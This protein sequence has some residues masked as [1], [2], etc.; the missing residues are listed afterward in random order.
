[1]TPSSNKSFNSGWNGIW[2]ERTRPWISCHGGQDAK[3]PCQT[4]SWALVL[5]ISAGPTIPLPPRASLIRWF[6]LAKLLPPVPAFG[7]RLQP[8]QQSLPWPSLGWQRPAIRLPPPASTGRLRTIPAAQGWLVSRYQ[9]PHEL[10]RYRG[11]QPPVSAIGCRC[12]FFMKHELI[13]IPLLGL[14]CWGWM[15][16]CAAIRE[17]FC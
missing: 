14:A 3:T 1:M 12:P 9:Q 8:A 5:F 13:Y 15:R 17:S 11:A 7:R 4:C 6:P 2:H 16:P 10:D